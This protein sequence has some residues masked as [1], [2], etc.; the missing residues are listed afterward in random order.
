LDFPFIN[1]CKK[2]NF[3]CELIT[4][5]L[6]ARREIKIALKEHLKIFVTTEAFFSI[7]S[8][9]VYFCVSESK[10][11]HIKTKVFTSHC[12]FVSVKVSQHVKFKKFFAFLLKVIKKE[13]NTWY[14]T[15][16]TKKRKIV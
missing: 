14:E 15:N 12:Y 7:S 6:F 3:F 16:K 11:K 5:L 8:I 13:R 10:K 4:S 1:L 9:R 2:K